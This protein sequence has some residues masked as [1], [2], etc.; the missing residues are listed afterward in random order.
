M[1]TT[2]LLIVFVLSIVCGFTTA[3]AAKPFL[4]GFDANYAI[5]MAESGKKWNGE[6]DPYSQLAQAGGN[7]FRV[8]LWTG[9]D[10]M[11]GLHYATET[12]KRA[13]AA[14]LKPYLVIF[15]SDNWADLVKQPVPAIWKDL[16]EPAKL[17]AIEAYSAKVTKHFVDAGV[18]I[19]F[20]EIGNEIDFGICGVFE[21]EW[22]KR[23]SIDYMRSQIFSKMAPIIAAAQR[24]VR[25]VDADA[26]F[27]LHLAQWHETDY[28]IEF[29][30]FMTANGVA[31][32][33]AGLSYFPTSVKGERT[34]LAFIEKQIE[35]IA[36]TTGKPIIICEYA[37][38]SQPTFEGQ[39]KDWNNPVEG[40]PLDEA[41]QAKWI[42][43]F[44]SRMRSN[45]SV[46][47]A[48]YWSPEWYGSNMW[49]AFC[50][51]NDDGS[52]KPAMKAFGT[53]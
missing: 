29:F 8:R 37:F 5:D 47:G 49:E 30:K 18:K 10:G 39:F 6:T 25:Q 17:A 1:N 40:Y 15:L 48:F 20:Y 23:V 53:K 22:P 13:Q 32:D 3:R 9:D 16:D 46:A 45:K 14:G 31:L 19:E 50:L 11:N 38:P 7:A 2:H 21:E 35:T 26:K 41:G 28:C 44:L 4:T 12:A 42:A 36:V 43:E 34:P 51:F 24:G 52:P 27:M 33:Y